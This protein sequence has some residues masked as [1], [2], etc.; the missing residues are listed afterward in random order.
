MKWNKLQSERKW[1]IVY[2]FFTGIYVVW[3]VFFTLPIGY[4]LLA[5]ILGIILLVAECL[6]IFD[7][8]IHFI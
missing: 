6:G 3:R 7:F 2:I 8:L 1:L 4:G 5:F